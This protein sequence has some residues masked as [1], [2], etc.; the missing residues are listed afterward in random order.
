MTKVNGDSVT[1]LLARWKNGQPQALDQLIERVYGELLRIGHRQMR[2][3]RRGHTL[4]TAG[5]VHEAYLRLV[6][7]R[8]IDWRDRHHFFTVAAAIMRRVLVDQA[9]GNG[10]LKRGGDALR[11]T[12]D[13]DLPAA[14]G[15]VDVVALDDAL[16]RL[17]ER[18]AT[19]AQ[20]V[21]LRYFG[22]LTVDEAAEV[23]A[24]APATVKRKWT[25]AQAWLYRELHDAN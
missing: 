14:Q 20:I 19:Q 4:Q 18:D 3:E 22:G 23:L 8:Q 11:M 13:E 1:Q 6:E 9:R 5:L 7:L 12:L 21:E 17:A 15:A 2:R 16:R 25:L 10:A 24:I